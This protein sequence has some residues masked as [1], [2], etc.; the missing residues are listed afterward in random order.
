MPP[1]ESATRKRAGDRRRR[2]RRRTRP[3]IT[4]AEAL[5]ADNDND[6][7]IFDLL[8]DE[9][10]REKRARLQ[11]SRREPQRDPFAPLLASGAA[12]LVGAG[13]KPLT[14]AE[15]RPLFD[16]GE[17]A[18]KQL[19]ALRPHYPTEAGAAS[20]PLA[21]A[22]V[23]HG[24]S[25]RV[26]SPASAALAEQRAHIVAQMA[27]LDHRDA[28]WSAFATS[29]AEAPSVQ[30]RSRAAQRNCERFYAQ[31]ERCA[32]LGGARATTT[33]KPPAEARRLRAQWSALLR[34]EVAAVRQQLAEETRTAIQRML[35]RPYNTLSAADAEARAAALTEGV[36]NQVA[37]RVLRAQLAQIDSSNYEDM[38][39]LAETLQRYLAEYLSLSVQPAAAAAADQE[40]TD[41][42]DYYA[43]T[44][45]R[46]ATADYERW[47]E[48]WLATAAEPLA[49]GEARAV[50]LRRYVL[51]L[52]EQRRAAD[53]E[54]AAGTT[55]NGFFSAPPTMREA[56]AR[57]A[58][59][60]LLLDELALDRARAVA[61]PDAGGRTGGSVALQ[62]AFEEYL[63]S[64]ATAQ[65][66][67]VAALL[68]HPT[69]D[70][71]A[72]LDAAVARR[73]GAIPR[74]GC[75]GGAGDDDVRLVTARA[76][77][78]ERQ[79]RERAAALE[80]LVAALGGPR[81][82]ATAPHAPDE[83]AS[84]ALVPAELRA[85]LVAEGRRTLGVQD[86][87]DTGLEPTARSAAVV[88][89]TGDAWSPF[90]LSYPLDRARTGARMDELLGRVAAGRADFDAA[91]S[92]EAAQE[93]RRAL[94]A[95]FTRRALRRQRAELEHALE[96]ALATH[97]DVPLVERVVVPSTRDVTLR[98]ELR[99]SPLL[100]ARILAARDPAQDLSDAERDAERALG[101]EP[102]EVRWYF[103]PRFA[104]LY[105]GEREVRR[106][107]LAPP[108][109]GDALLA[110]DATAD[111]E[112]AV[113]RAG[114][115]RVE[116]RR[117]TDVYR[118]EF[119]A[120]VRVLAH[121]VRDDA[122]FEPLPDGSDP[123]PL[124]CAWRAAPRDEAQLELLE[125]LAVLVHGG[126]DA[127]DALRV[128]RRRESLGDAWRELERIA[129]A[130]GAALERPQPPWGASTPVAF[131][132]LALQDEAA[133]RARFLFDALVARVVRRVAG[134][135]RALSSA[136][137]TADRSN[138]DLFRSA[139]REQIDT[140]LRAA[141]ERGVDYA[142]ALAAFRVAAPDALRGA[143]RADADAVSRPPAPQRFKTAVRAAIGAT[144]AAFADDAVRV[145]SGTHR[146]ALDVTLAADGGAAA[147]LAALARGSGDALAGASLAA[148]LQCMA[149]PYV[150]LLLTV[151]ERRFVARVADRFERFAEHYRQREL[152]ARFYTVGQLSRPLA[153]L[154]AA[155]IEARNGG[156]LRAEIDSDLALLS[157]ERVRELAGD[158]RAFFFDA[159]S[160]AEYR[161]LAHTLAP[162][163]EQL[164]RVDECC[165][166]RAEWRGTHSA[167]DDQPRPLQVVFSGELAAERAALAHAGATPVG[168]L[169]DF[170]G[171][172]AVVER[173]IVR[174]NAAVG[175]DDAA[176]AEDAR[177][178]VQRAALVFN[179][180]ALVAPRA[181]EF[182]SAAALYERLGR[183]RLH[184][185]PPRGE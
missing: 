177:A 39:L 142:A 87:I 58:Y 1:T 105:G 72:L 151:R 126:R 11:L 101:A 119:A 33:L 79:L 124:Q 26:P 181:R 178:D 183:S 43:D 104:A 12:P 20:V 32:A 36:L 143:A 132:Q 59:R 108:Q 136:A 161:R 57:A 88:R 158:G 3:V 92:H 171:L 70:R 82:R 51:R 34:Q 134:V 109:T 99:L 145:A 141:D 135:V 25:A 8:E 68:A 66:Q 125:E 144:V 153:A 17:M 174:F 75:A 179:Y 176:A 10:Q 96:H 24:L 129:A 6:A 85:A 55:R 107:R 95:N 118:S 19:A 146:V 160:W 67:T 163:A 106:A 14:A 138:A 173:Q 5:R 89:D 139:C 78:L 110:L 154:R 62:R 28:Q 97:H 76:Q 115:Y 23:V 86:A 157:A 140:L 103:R 94:E 175:S 73:R 22:Y 168:H 35:Q 112:H 156:A 74:A 63:R 93:T 133:V 91:A 7:D 180:F 44:L 120:T 159:D 90:D 184:F 166:E 77:V 167:L 116:F 172:R 64:E 54:R 128:Q 56:E 60:Q 130:R 45:E 162:D 71:F 117:G 131:A 150:Q 69:R 137:E 15:L 148:V 127:L 121:C 50:E 52:V 27:E 53:A 98:A 81:I 16:V 46:Y 2:R 114:S 4:A 48:C 84:A 100:E 123:V 41:L 152:D 38:P 83:P 49:V 170:A 40:Q 165:A 18:R 113:A 80:E 13:A 155:R 29:V 37:D 185:E 102:F 30:Q 9:L 61:E 47:F 21:A 42:L 164:A 147:L 182:V 31:L 111:L 122:L 65:E 149:L 169:Y